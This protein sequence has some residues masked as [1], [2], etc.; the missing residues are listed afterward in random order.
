MKESTFN[1]PICLKVLFHQKELGDK[2]DIKAFHRHILTCLGPI[3]MLEECVKEEE[4]LSFIEKSPI[5]DERISR[6]LRTP[7]FDGDIETGSY[8]ST[9]KNVPYTVIIIAISIF[10]NL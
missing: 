9:I 2:F 10:L 3:E 5:D 8:P 1:I 4:N 7:R 6:E